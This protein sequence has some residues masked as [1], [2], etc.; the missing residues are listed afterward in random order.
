MC[1]VTNRTEFRNQGFYLAYSDFVLGYECLVSFAF[2]KDRSIL[3]FAK[4]SMSKHMLGI[5]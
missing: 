2:P 3:L 4:S 1:S 5:K